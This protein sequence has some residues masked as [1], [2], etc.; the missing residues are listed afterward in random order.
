VSNQRLQAT[1]ANP[2]PRWLPPS[3]QLDCATLPT[4]GAATSQFKACRSTK[5]FN[6]S[7]LVRRRG[8]G[9]GLLT[10]ADLQDLLTTTVVSLVDVNTNEAVASFEAPAGSALSGSW[11]NGG[12]SLGILSLAPGAQTLVALTPGAT[13][14]VA[15]VTQALPEGTVLTSVTQGPGGRLIFT[16]TTAGEPPQVL[17]VDPSSGN[18]VGVCVISRPGTPCGTNRVC[19]DAKTCVVSWCPPVGYLRAGCT[20][21]ARGVNSGVVGGFT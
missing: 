15:P 5:A 3:R 11:F 20:H 10:L 19:G 17:V 16:V 6:F 21:T 14:V 7:A 1:V 18:A 9:R 12:N 13:N 2:C 8:R 4:T